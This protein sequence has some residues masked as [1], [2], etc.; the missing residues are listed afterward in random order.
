MDEIKKLVIKKFGEDT[1]FGHTC[2]CKECLAKDKILQALKLMKLVEEES[3]KECFSKECMGCEKD[4]I[5][6]LLEEA[7]K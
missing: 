6:N 1:S 2:D 7:K 3:N 5:R 4:Y